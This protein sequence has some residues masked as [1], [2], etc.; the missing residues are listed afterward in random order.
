M[1]D[2]RVKIK[3]VLK[4]VSDTLPYVYGRGDDTWNHTIV[5][6][7]ID[8]EVVKGARCLDGARAVID[9][10]GGIDGYKKILYHLRHPEIDGYFALLIGLDDDFNSEYIELKEMNHNLKWLA[11]YIKEFEVEHGLIF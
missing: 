11:K 9:D 8:S 10:C 6:E 4:E 3:S 2:K 1:W 5:L 7:K